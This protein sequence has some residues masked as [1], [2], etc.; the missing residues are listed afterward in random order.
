MPQVINT[1]VMSLNA[2]RNL[3]TSSGS[4]AV[5]LQRLSSGLRINSAKDD[6]AGLAISQRMSAQIRSLNQ[7]VRNANDGISMIQT[8]EGAMDQI[9]NMMQ[10]MKELSTQAASDTVGATER[11]FLNNEMQQLKDE[12]NAIAGRT[13]FNGQKLLNGSFAVALDATSTAQVGTNLDTTAEA[14]ITGISV[15]GATASSTY[16]LTNAAGVVTLDDG[17]GQSQAIDLTGVT[18]AGGSS[19]TLDFSSL[20]VSITVSAAASKAGADVGT[21]LNGLTV[22]TGAASSAVVQVGSSSSADNRISLSFVDVQINATSGLSA[23]NTALSDFNSA[24]T[25]VNAR[26]LLDSVE[27]ALNFVSEQRANLGA[28][29][30]RLEYTVANIQATVENLSA[31][32]SRILDADFASETASLTRAQILQQAGTAILAQANAVPQNVLALLR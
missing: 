14:A 30:N 31:S 25:V 15:A 27:G 26:A 24:Q 23:I 32:R 29:Q 17:A 9:Q 4:L 18:I 2:Q 22:V 11:G 6:A 5:A 13:E 28:Q 3:T 21:D 1:N 7:A 12:I 19:Y 20:G 16:T 8:G 10:R